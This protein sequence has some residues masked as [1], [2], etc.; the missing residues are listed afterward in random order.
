MLLQTDG[1]PAD[2]DRLKHKQCVSNGVGQPA[3]IRLPLATEPPHWLALC[4]RDG[5]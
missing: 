2:C 5:S 1:L 3:V 4:L